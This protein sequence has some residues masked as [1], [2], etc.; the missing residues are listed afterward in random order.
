M[1]R[2][3]A[4]HGAGTV[5]APTLTQALRAAGFVHAKRGDCSRNEIFDVVSG[6]SM[7]LFR[8]HEA[9][10]WLRQRMRS[11]TSADPSRM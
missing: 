6:E 11:S 3:A 7:G 5:S 9:W 10:E 2:G 4:Y 1:A 8:P